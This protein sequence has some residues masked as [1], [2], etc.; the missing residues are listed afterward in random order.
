MLK[1]KSVDLKT[2]KFLTLNS[3]SPKHSRFYLIPKNL[4]TN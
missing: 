3:A 4:R 2:Y 1:D